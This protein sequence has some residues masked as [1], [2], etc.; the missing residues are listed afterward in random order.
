MATP[1]TGRNGA[2]YVD[3][4]LAG[5]GSASK[6]ANLNQWSLQQTR[7]KTEVTSFGASSKTYVFGLAD[8]SGSFQGFHDTDGT[9][10][11]VADGNPRSMYLYPSTADTTKYW[12]GSASF[13][14]TVSA[15]VGG[16]VDVSG[17]FAAA[18]PIQYVG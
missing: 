11:K 4:S 15:S 18:T 12:F 17:N 5:T 13:D 9:L 2:L 6:I 8:A 10:Q 1:I 3:T 7:D 14:I 16:A